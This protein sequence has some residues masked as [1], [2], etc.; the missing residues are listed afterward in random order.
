M[1]G[2]SGCLSQHRAGSLS[3]DSNGITSL[4]AEG[5]GGLPGPSDFTGGGILKSLAAEV[6]GEDP[7]MTKAA[8]RGEVPSPQLPVNWPPTTGS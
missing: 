3:L 8:S 1:L 2:A 4:S 6:M 7:E 5:D